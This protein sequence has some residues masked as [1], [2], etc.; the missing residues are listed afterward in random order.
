MVFF[1]SGQVCL[2]L[3]KIRFALSLWY[4]DSALQ[5]PTYACGWLCSPLPRGGVLS[6]RNGSAGQ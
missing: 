5:A 2:L 6:P 1:L 3:N 4:E